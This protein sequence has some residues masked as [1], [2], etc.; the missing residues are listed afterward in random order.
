MQL[1]KIHKLPNNMVMIH[2]PAILMLS[3]GRNK[4]PLIQ[5]TLFISCQ[6]SGKQCLFVWTLSTL[7]NSTRTLNYNDRKLD[8]LKQQCSFSYCYQKFY[9]PIQTGI[10]K[11]ISFCCCIHWGEII[12]KMLQKYYTTLLLLPLPDISLAYG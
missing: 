4:R 10:K 12:S 2:K 9:I 5:S 11:P 6:T 1:Q 3:D 8:L 7:D